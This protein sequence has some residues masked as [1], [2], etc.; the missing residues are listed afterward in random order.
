MARGGISLRA[1]FSCFK[2]NIIIFLFIIKRNTPRAARMTLRQRFFCACG[3]PR[4]GIGVTSPKRDGP[5]H[6]HSPYHSLYHSLYH[7]PYLYHNHN[8]Y[9]NRKIFM[10]LIP[11]IKFWKI[12]KTVYV[13]VHELPFGNQG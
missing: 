8:H 9:H 4:G 10:D 1:L 12:F 11:Q 2:N 6:H 7:N 13:S 3:Q 5:D